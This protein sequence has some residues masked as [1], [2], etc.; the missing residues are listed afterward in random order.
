MGAVGQ[1]SRWGLAAL[2]GVPLLLVAVIVVVLIPRAAPGVLAGAGRYEVCSFSCEAEPGE[3]RAEAGEGCRW[4]RFAGGR[5]VDD[6]E[7]AAGE[8]VTVTLE[9]GETF[10]MSAG[11]GP[12][13]EV[14]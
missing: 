8:V 5:V 13:T 12:W 7:A 2:I 14:D 6:G 4:V 11:C 10:S 9:D 1:R 3:W